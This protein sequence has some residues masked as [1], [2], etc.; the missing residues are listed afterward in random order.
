MSMTI[1][2][3]VAM[4]LSFVLTLFGIESSKEEVDALTEQVVAL[5]GV[6]TFIVSAIITYYG[7]YRQGDINA[8]GIKTEEK[9]PERIIKP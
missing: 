3:L 6:L 9:P 8:I 5:V 2:G 7:R 4:I 1:G